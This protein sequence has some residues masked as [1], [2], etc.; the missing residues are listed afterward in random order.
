VLSIVFI[1]V[2]NYE[3]LEEVYGP[4]ACRGLIQE[5]AE[6]VATAAGATPTISAQC[7]GSFFLLLPDIDLEGALAIAWHVERGLPR[8]TGVGGILMPVEASVHVEHNDGMARTVAR[9]GAR[10]RR[11]A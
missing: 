4:E 8:Q 3:G 1:S 7:P 11:A 2:T 9:V 5:T 6:S 10:A